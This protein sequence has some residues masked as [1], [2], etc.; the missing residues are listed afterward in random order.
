VP[1]IKRLDDIFRYPYGGAVRVFFSVQNPAFFRSATTTRTYL[2]GSRYFLA[3]D[4]TSSLVT[5]SMYCGYFL[6]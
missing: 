5:E 2:S 1:T 6:S 3:T 4:M